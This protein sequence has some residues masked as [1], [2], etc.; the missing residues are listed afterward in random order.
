MEVLSRQR[1][2][3][4]L[5][6]ISQSKKNSRVRNI[7]T[8]SLQDVQYIKNTAHKAVGK[9]KGDRKVSTVLHNVRLKTNPEVVL[10]LSRGTA[11]SRWRKDNQGTSSQK[12]SRDNCT[13]LQKRSFLPRNEVLWCEAGTQE[14]LIDVSALGYGHAVK[15]ALQWLLQH[16]GYSQTHIVILYTLNNVFFYYR[17]YAVSNTPMSLQI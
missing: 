5:P 17:A 9:H 16:Q 10:A 7:G 6:G 15:V 8:I 11:T 1:K 13:S 2:Q 14:P 3:I 4:D 12:G